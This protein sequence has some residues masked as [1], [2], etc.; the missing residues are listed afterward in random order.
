MP[1]P[2]VALVGRPNVGKSTLF[3]RLVGEPLAIV[4]GVP[5]TTR[6][7]LI[8]EAE[9]TGHPFLVV[10]T[11]G[12][13]P[14]VGGERP[15]SLGSA[16]Y[17]EQIRAQA[18]MAIEEA[19][20]V[21]FLVDASSGVTPADMEVA[22]LLR[23]K[24]R[25]LEGK[26]HP[27]V[28]LVVNKADNENLRQQAAQFYELGLGEPYAVSALHGLGIGDLL[29]EVVAHFPPAVET[30]E[31][32]A[33]KIAIVGR[34]NVGKSSLLNR[35]VGEERAIVSPIAGTT[36]DAIDT[37]IEY[38]GMRIVLIDTAGIR[39]R[40]RIEPGVEKYSVLRTLRAIERCDVALLMLDATTGITA[41]DAHIAGYILEANKSVVVLVNKWD[42]VPK[43]SQTMQEYTR[44]IRQELNFMDYVPILFISA[45]TG[46]RVDQ[47]LPLALKV[48]EERLAR[49]PTAHLNRILQAAQDAHTP[50]SR[51]GKSLRIYYGTQV[52]S[53]P[54]TFLIYVNDPRL[55][56][57]TYL[58]YLE[59]CIRREYPFTGT[60]IRL[61]LKP[62][63]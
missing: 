45:K 25:I 9:W 35:L 32:E 54:P 48:Q 36:R 59:N 7:R 47:V 29:D 27:P 14:R 56:H 42:A 3:N 26:P 33:V 61:V 50:T 10:D 28:L 51:T 18:E 30:E 57:F 23:R 43:D 62:R 12:I 5:G 41:Q 15:L 31:E 2:L 4:D 13:D 34:P 16:E 53:D 52:R 39:R 22:N 46:Q 60:P 20:V 63:R 55:A 8:A 19:D 1:K 58:R 40:G 11:G 37:P 24:Q 21:L 49:L 17:I 38:Q 6:D 44:R